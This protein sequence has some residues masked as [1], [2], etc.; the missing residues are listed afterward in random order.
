QN[1]GAA[2]LW[3]KR[4]DAG[5]VKGGV[6][7][8]GGREQDGFTAWNRTRIPVAAFSLFEINLE[9][10]PVVP[11][12]RGD[13]CQAAR[14]LRYEIDRAVIAPAATHVAVGRADLLCSAA[15]QSQFA[16]CGIA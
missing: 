5:V 10:F 14:E 16:Y 1:F 15:A 3:R 7:R 12:R 13:T 8:H 6:I 9:H 11:T 2:G 4:D